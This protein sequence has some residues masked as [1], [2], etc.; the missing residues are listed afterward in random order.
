MNPTV[1]RC[2]VSGTLI[3]AAQQIFECQQ[4]V[5]F[6]ICLDDTSSVSCVARYRPLKQLILNTPPGTEIVVSG[7]ICFDREGQF[8]VLTYRAEPPAIFG[9][10]L[11][12]RLEHVRKKYA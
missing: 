7:K 1:N 12:H 9:Q 2:Q 5:R 11:D 3:Q 8:Y 6:E 10:R 4:I